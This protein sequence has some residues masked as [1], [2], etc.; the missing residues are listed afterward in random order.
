MTYDPHLVENLRQEIAR[1]RQG[2][3]PRDFDST[4]SQTSG[5]RSKRLQKA[6]ARLEA[7]PDA[8]RPVVQRWVPRIF[9]PFFRNQGGANRVLAQAVKALAEENSQFAREIRGQ[10]ASLRRLH[11]LLAEKDLRLRQLEAEIKK[12]REQDAPA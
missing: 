1:L 7:L 5:S 4:A 8:P 9:W 3:A 10:R 6:L 12:G 2:E 11:E